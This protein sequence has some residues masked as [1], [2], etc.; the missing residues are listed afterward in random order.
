MHDEKEQTRASGD[1]EPDGD[2]VRPQK[3]GEGGTTR[4][5]MEDGDNTE[6]PATGAGAAE[7]APPERPR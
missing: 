3:G 7:E 1:G 4:L 5:G 2:A 6:V